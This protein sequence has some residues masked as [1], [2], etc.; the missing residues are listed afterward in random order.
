NRNLAG[1]MEDMRRLY[2]AMEELV[3]LVLQFS[4][5][6]TAIKKEKAIVDFSDLEHFCLAILTE[7]MDGTNVVPSDV[8]LQFQK[9]FKIG[10]AS[11]RERVW[12]S[13]VCS[14]DLIWKI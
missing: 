13:D 9:Q 5:R 6:F 10:R 2:P 11:C 7:K 12:I 4:E 3:S 14:S 8:A 1:H